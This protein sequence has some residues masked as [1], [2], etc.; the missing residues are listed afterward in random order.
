[1]KLN[2]WKLLDFDRI[3]LY[4]YE[5]R[6]IKKL[7]YKLNN[8]FQD[9]RRHHFV[10]NDS[11]LIRV[12]KKYT[13]ESVRERDDDDQDE[14]AVWSD[15]LIIKFKEVNSTTSR[16][17][18]YRRRTW[19]RRSYGRLETIRD[20]YQIE[21]DDENQIDEYDDGDRKEYLIESILLQDISRAYLDADRRTARVELV[22]RNKSI[23]RRHILMC[24]ENEIVHLRFR[25]YRRRFK[26]LSE[27]N[28]WQGS[29]KISWILPISTT[30][31]LNF[32]SKSTLN[33]DSSSSILFDFLWMMKHFLEV[34]KIVTRYVL[35]S[36]KDLTATIRSISETKIR[37]NYSTFFFSLWRHSSYSWHLDPQN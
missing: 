24:I 32:F 15:R 22:T 7:P 13:I 36:S 16:I 2:L 28:F 20:R 11:F 19:W 8:I 25:T 5:I 12:R 17:M 33:F 1:M 3:V 23:P 10:R 9:V 27:T 21:R 35:K 30:S 34:M 31:S 29:W 37:M 26:F 4:S 6:K 14:T 18:W